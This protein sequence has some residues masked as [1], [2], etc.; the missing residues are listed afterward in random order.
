LIAPKGSIYGYKERHVLMK[1]KVR[2]NGKLFLE[3]KE[4]NEGMNRGE[5]KA[6]CC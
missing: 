6:P 5:N 1:K 4:T 2:K 3:A